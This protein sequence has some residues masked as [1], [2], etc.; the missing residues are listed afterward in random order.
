MSASSPLFCAS[1]GSIELPE[2]SVY[3]ACCLNGDGSLTA[4]ALAL[5]GARRHAAEF[6]GQVV[7]EQLHHGCE[8][9]DALTRANLPDHA[10]AVAVT[11]RNGLL[12]QVMVPA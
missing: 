4:L 10:S 3:S 9:A 6:L 11:L 2:N 5:P 1:I 7:E 12:T 8:P